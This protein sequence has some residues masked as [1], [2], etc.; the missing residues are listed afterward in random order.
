[1]AR[2]PILTINTGSSSLKAALYAPNDGRVPAVSARAERIGRAG[3]RL[4]I[5]GSSGETL[6]EHHAAIPDHAAAVDALLAWLR[7]AGA[8]ASPAAIGHRVVHGG[9][10]YAAPV[11]VAP[12]MLD[13]LR[14]VTPLAPDHLPQALAAIEAAGRAY[15]GVPQVACF[16]TAF[17]RRMPRVAQVYPLP[18]RLTDAGVRRYG[19]HGLSYESILEDLHRIDPAAAGGR[20]LIAHLG[21]GASMAAVRAGVGTDT[22]MGFTPAG[23]LMMGTRTGDLDPGVLLHLLR[24]EGHTPAELGALVTERSGLLGVSGASAD[25]RDLLEREGADARA[26][27]AVALFCYQ[28]RKFAGAMTAALG[29]VETLVFTGGIGERS[30]AV[31]ERICAG[32]GFLGVRLDPTRNAAH[33]PV[34]SL[35]NAPATVRVM[36]T[37]EDRMIAGHTARLVAQGGA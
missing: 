2:G 10:R 13:A 35:D 24:A 22:T 28:A 15:P 4:R 25:M 5:A 23:G 8:S 9:N 3:S 33:A 18:R 27:E 19:F 16:D 37:D 34:I 7:D 30:A 21:N 11:I 17:H 6:F 14:E 12:G 31:R 1:M 26:A 32:L 20:V 29:G 36:E